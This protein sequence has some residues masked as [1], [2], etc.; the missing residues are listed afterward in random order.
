MF[1]NT[2]RL[3]KSSGIGQRRKSELPRRTA[4]Q[5]VASAGWGADFQTPKRMPALMGMNFASLP[6]T[7]TLWNRPS[8]KIPILS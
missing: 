7:K 1:E 6:V 5:F 4:G 8:T 2:G 3:V